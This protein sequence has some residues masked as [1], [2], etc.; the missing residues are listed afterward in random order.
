MLCVGEICCYD[1]EYHIFLIQRS[2][3]MQ[4]SRFMMKKESGLERQICFV[5]C[6]IADKLSL[7][8]LNPLH[9]YYGC[10]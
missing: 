1:I 7:F 5:F 10:L 9:L 3:N 8:T 6:K 2:H 4:S